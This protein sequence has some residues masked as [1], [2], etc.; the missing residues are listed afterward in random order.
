MHDE[1]VRSLISCPDLAAVPNDA[2]QLYQIYEFM[3]VFE[4][5]A[6]PAPPL[7]VNGAVQTSRV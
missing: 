4:V 2:V 1:S 5:S 6:Q 3:P 7:P